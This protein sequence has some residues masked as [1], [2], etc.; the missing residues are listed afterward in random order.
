MLATSSLNVLKGEPLR[1]PSFIDRVVECLPAT[2]ALEVTAYSVVGL[3]RE[4]VMATTVKDEVS[5]TWVAYTAL[6]PN[7]VEVS[8][9]WSTP[10][11]RPTVRTLSVPALISSF[12]CTSTAAITAEAVTVTTEL[13]NCENMVPTLADKISVEQ[14]TCISLPQR[15]GVT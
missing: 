6:V 1:A 2:V 10:L 15:S 3:D 7:P 5:I 8:G 4:K 11:A 14:V 13:S 12:F 9:A